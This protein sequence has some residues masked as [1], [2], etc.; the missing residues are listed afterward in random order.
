MRKSKAPAAMIELKGIGRDFQ[1]G[2]Q[3]VH[4]LDG[5]DLDIARGDYVSIMGPSG[6]GKSTLLNLIGLLDR[7]SAGQYLLD[8]RDVTTLSDIE[9]ARTRNQLIGFVFQAFHLVPRMSAAGNVE[10]PLILAGVP[11]EQRAQEIADRI[12]AVQPPG[13][14]AQLAVDPAQLVEEQG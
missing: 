4:A 2:D 1:V 9:Q 12:P 8:G 13:H 5:I 14:A 10:L 6:S 3:V 7:A 11:A